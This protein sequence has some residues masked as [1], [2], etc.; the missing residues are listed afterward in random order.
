MS[1]SS[2]ASSCKAVWLSGRDDRLSGEAEPVSNLTFTHSCNLATLFI[3]AEVQFPHLLTE[4]DDI[5]LVVLL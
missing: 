3:P 4:G 5:F 1:H 2:Q